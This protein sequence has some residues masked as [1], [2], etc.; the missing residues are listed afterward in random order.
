MFVLL[1]S[2]GAQAAT[3]PRITGQ[4]FGEEKKADIVGYQAL[5]MDASAK[6]ESALA[7]EIVTEAFKA[8]GKT[9][10]VD[11]LPS[12]QLAKYA[13]L[14]NNVVALLGSPQ[15]LTEQEKNQYRVVTF[16]LKGS[17]PGEESVS[18]IFSKKNARGDEWH[19]AFNEGLQKILK[20]GKYLE[21]L[22]KD[23]GKGQVPSDYVN[24]LKRHNPGWK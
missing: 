4:M 9:P 2:C 15:D 3:A 8:A 10:T 21:I 18:L 14:N 17:A 16:F 5:P 7:M 1:C 13:L 11:L 20:N 19:Q 12:K 24:R 23:R 6:S 22:E